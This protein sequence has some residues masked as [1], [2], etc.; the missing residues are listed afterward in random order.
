MLSS[1]G[2]ESDTVLL[3]DNVVKIS[4]EKLLR[5]FLKSF[6]PKL[7]Q[8]SPFNTVNE[9]KKLLVNV[10]LIYCNNRLYTKA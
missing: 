10:G 8:V 5:E 7:T 2:L 4:S 6:S 1:T 3:F 9:L